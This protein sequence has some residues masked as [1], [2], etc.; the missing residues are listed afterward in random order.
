MKGLDVDICAPNAAF[1]QTPE[2]LQ[3]VRVDVALRV[4]LRMV[5]HLM[6]VFVSQL[7]VRAELV[8]MNLRAFLDVL[9]NLGVKVP[10][11]N[12]LNNLQSHP[13]RFIFGIALKQSEHSSFAKRFVAAFGLASAGTNIARLCSD[14]GFIH[15]HAALEFIKRALLHCEPDT[16]KQEPGS[17]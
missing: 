7:F 3:A 15:F 8:C 10:A 16:V 5:D 14:K 1:K 17:L 11:A 4:A 13:R 2:V 9:T 6:D 12:T